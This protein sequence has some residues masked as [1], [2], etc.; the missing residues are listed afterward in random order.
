M[1][2]NELSDYADW[3]EAETTQLVGDFVRTFRRLPGSAELIQFRH[4]VLT[5]YATDHRAGAHR[6]T[7]RKS[8]QTFPGDTLRS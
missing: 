6:R 3:D 7:A 5:S 2:T 1:N 4:A 8:L